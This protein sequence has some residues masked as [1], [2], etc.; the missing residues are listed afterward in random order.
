[1]LSSHRRY[2]ATEQNVDVKTETNNTTQSQ[3]EIGPSAPE[4]QVNNLT[5]E[6]ERKSR[7]IIFSL[8]FRLS[9]VI[10]IIEIALNRVDRRNAL[11]R[12]LLSQV[13]RLRRRIFYWIFMSLV[14]CD[15][16]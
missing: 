10:D 12:Q 6:H 9:F 2:L 8:K 3:P 15:N 16:G 4:L 1:M 13:D 7:H 14:G 5:G 11:G